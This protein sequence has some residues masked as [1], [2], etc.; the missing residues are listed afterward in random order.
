MK[1][2]LA[3]LMLSMLLLGCAGETSGDIDPNRIPLEDEPF[4]GNDSAKVTI[5]VFSDFQ[6]P[7]C[8]KGEDTLMTGVYPQ[9][10]GTIR[11]YF[12]HFPLTQIHQFAQK[13]AEAS[14]CAADQGKFWEMH[15]LLFANNNKLDSDSLKKYAVE[16][17]LDS[18]KFNQCLDSGEKAAVVNA[19]MKLG[20]S[21]GVRAT[22]TFYINGKKLEGAKP[23]Y[24]FALL[25]DEELKK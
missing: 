4:L 25:I 8:K 24:S 17:G 11:I 18:E 3:L 2:V 14:E 6:C 22:P 10:N 5:V 20:E 21:L 12:K 1:R 19:D 23:A 16:L 15:D 7:F 13:A 9:Y